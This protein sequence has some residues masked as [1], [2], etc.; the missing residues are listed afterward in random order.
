MKTHEIYIYDEIGPDYYGLVSGKS[1]VDGLKEFSATDGDKLVVRINS[2]G[3]DVFQAKAIGQAIERW[4]GPTVAEIDSIAASAATFIAL[5]ADE[6]TMAED[7]MFMIHNAWTVAMGDAAELRHAANTLDMIGGT[8]IDSYEQK[9][10]LD[11][12]QIVDMMDAETWM[13]AQQAAD[14]GFV[15]NI[16]SPQKIAA[17]IRPGMFSRLPDGWKPAEKTQ[18]QKSVLSPELVK[19]KV[20]LRR[21][22]LGA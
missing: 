21:R 13:T 4:V 15:D 8:I 9:T 6:V 16:S 18:H 2:P 11:R 12:G 3:G 20:E 7:A 10:G 22:T 5:K 14:H 17:C 19:Y 1:F